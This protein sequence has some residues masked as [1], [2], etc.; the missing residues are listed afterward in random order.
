MRGWQSKLVKQIEQIPK[1]NPVAI[2]TPRVVAGGLRRAGHGVVAAKPGHEGKP[3]DVV[4]QANSQS[5][6]ARPVIGRS[7]GKGAEAISAV[8]IHIHAGPPRSRKCKVD[9][10]L[11]FSST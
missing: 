7:I 2:V 1:A 3:F 10:V 6:A 5:F 8:I 11:A 4:A 9:K